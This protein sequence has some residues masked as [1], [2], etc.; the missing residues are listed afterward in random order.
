MKPV[1]ITFYAYAEHESDGVTL[2]RQIF[3]FVIRMYDEGRLVTCE[4]IS[5]ALAS[6]G[7]NP[8]VKQYFHGTE[9][10]RND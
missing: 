6:F 5:N 3:D 7:N 2:E 9:T 1:K 4:R 10:K 8:L